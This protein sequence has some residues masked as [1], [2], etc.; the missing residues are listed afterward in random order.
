MQKIVKY[1]G[2]NVCCN[3]MVDALNDF[4]INFISDT[5]DSD[6]FMLSICKYSSNSSPFYRR[7]QYCPFCA[8]KIELDIFN[9]YGV[10]IKAGDRVAE[11]EV[12]VCRNKNLGSSL[13][14]TEHGYVESV[15]GDFYKMTTE[16]FIKLI[17]N[18][19][20]IQKNK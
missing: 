14:V 18:I 13:I 6:V 19:E 4:Y 2:W 1:E 8:K 7:I 17:K 3:G 20:A 10:K 15:M 16:D 11:G 5:S 12:C 9:L